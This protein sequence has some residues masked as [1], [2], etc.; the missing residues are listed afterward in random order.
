MVFLS[1]A[2]AQ[3][4]GVSEEGIG[5][6]ILTLSRFHPLFSPP[7]YSFWKERQKRSAINWRCPS[8]RF[9]FWSVGSHLYE[10][11]YTF[12][13]AV[14]QLF[15]G[16]CVSAYHFFSILFSPWSPLITLV[17]VFRTKTSSFGFA[18]P[19]STS[20]WPLEI[21]KLFFVAGFYMQMTSVM[22]G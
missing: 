7:S 22:I 16:P 20:L 3:S 11:V 19:F 2:I 12:W 17:K 13:P 10:C 8:H 15:S 5:Y 14:E 6:F 1:T 21:N 9:S 4:P 18:R